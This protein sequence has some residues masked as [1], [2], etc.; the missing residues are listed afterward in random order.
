VELLFVTLQKNEKRF[1]PT[2]LYHDYAMSQQLFHWQ[3]QNSARPDRGKGL[4]YV[5]QKSNGKEI[6]LWVRESSKDEYE[7]TRGFVN[8]GWV[9]LKALPARSQ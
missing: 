4:S 5:K 6:M 2:T 1:S 7:N 9:D 3:S 8:F